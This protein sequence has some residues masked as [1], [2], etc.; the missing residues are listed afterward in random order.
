MP[1]MS[2]VANC[3]VLLTVMAHN[4]IGQNLPISSTSEEAIELFKKGRDIFHL[5]WFEEAPEY[6]LEAID[7]DS[8]LAI[9]HAYLAMSQYF[10]FTDCIEHQEILKWRM[11][12]WLK[13]II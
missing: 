2:K 8:T 5:T 9:A 4:T 11:P 6:F 7:K 3:L 10:K 1:T 13:Q 12:F